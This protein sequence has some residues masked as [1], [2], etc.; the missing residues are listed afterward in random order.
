MSPYALLPRRGPVAL[1]PLS[2]DVRLAAVFSALFCREGQ[3]GLAGQPLPGLLCTALSSGS[4]FT[5]PGC[6]HSQGGSGLRGGGL[7]RAAFLP[8][9]RGL[10]DTRPSSSFPC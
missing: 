5:L 1:L 6:T 2:W 4:S 3:V 10:P 7:L 8:L 9:L